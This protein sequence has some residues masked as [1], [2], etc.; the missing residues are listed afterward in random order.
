MENEGIRNHRKEARLN[1]EGASFLY[2][3]LAQLASSSVRGHSG[4]KDSDKEEDWLYF[5]LRKQYRQQTQRNR[6]LS[7]YEVFRRSIPI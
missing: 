3:T 1:Q 2:L 5:F 6:L 4:D 7:E